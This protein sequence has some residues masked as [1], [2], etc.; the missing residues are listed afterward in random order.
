MFFCRVNQAQN[1]NPGYVYILEVRDIDL[2]VC[3]IGRTS[4]TPSARCAEINRS[5]T[6]DFLWQVA[7]QFSVNDCNRFERLVHKKLEPF[8]QK[9]REFFNV[10]AKVAHD[11]VQSILENQ[12][13]I[14]EISQKELEEVPA[15]STMPK[16]RRVIRQMQF[17]H[18]DSE[19]AQTLALFTQ[20][21]GCKGQPFGQLNKPRFGM[22]DGND[23]V[24][25][26]IAIDTER[27]E[28]RLGVNLEGMKYDNWPIRTLLLKE[29]DNPTFFETRKYLTS[30]ECIFMTLTRDAWQVTSRPSIVE[31]SICPEHC[32]LNTIDPLLWRSMLNEAL[33]C[34]SEERDYLGR[35][36]QL[37]TLRNRPKTG[38]Q[39]RVMEVSPHL[40]IWTRIEPLG[41]KK[42]QIRSGIDRLT[43]IYE[44]VT[45]RIEIQR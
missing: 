14:R 4:K 29:L 35:A 11:A 7:Y 19:Y 13:I 31:E 44:W 34:L 33:A 40:T 45:R 15:E 39:R 25:W 27:V 8:R 16:K 37:V 38:N 26:N 41:D 3:K 20:I 36:Q 23:G 6:G 22:S 10:A 9:G 21:V 42:A 32:P 5:S 18:Q 28:T 43:P 24:Q 2:P 1:E 12:T 17:R 30:P